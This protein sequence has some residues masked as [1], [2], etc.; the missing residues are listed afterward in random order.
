MKIMKKKKTK[1]KK[2]R[3]SYLS[4]TRKQLKSLIMDVNDQNN[5]EI[6]DIILKNNDIKS[7]EQALAMLL[8]IEKYKQIIIK[9]STTRSDN[10]KIIDNQPSDFKDVFK[11]I[12]D[13]DFDLFKTLTDLEINI[14][15][16]TTQ[17]KSMNDFYIVLKNMVKDI[18]QEKEK[19]TVHIIY[20][21]LMKKIK[22]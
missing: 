3:T 2:V 21:S 4:K 10:I 11:Q 18:E 15:H 13:K 1:K 22:N 20:N 19:K 6:I 5:D 14:K 12:Y 9:S 16:C 7:T 17:L 8:E